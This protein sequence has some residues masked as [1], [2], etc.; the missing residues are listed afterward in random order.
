MQEWSEIV[1]EDELIEDTPEVVGSRFRTVTEERGKQMT[2]EG[3][4]TGYEH[5]KRQA[6]HMSG[7]YFNIET[8]F[9]FEDLSGRTRVTQVADVRG[10]GF[11]KLILWVSGV[12]MKKSQ[13][14]AAQKELE[15]LKRH[16]ESRQPAATQ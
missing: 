7:Q 4:V 14:E 15:N 8:E 3:I 2:F 13:C 9:Q 6:V 10:K 5:P 11:F 1:I 16:C 12:F